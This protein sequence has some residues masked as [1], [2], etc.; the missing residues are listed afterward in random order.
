MKSSLKAKILAIS[1]E[2]FDNGKLRYL[3][4]KDYFVIQTAMNIAEIK[5]KWFVEEKNQ[6]GILKITGIK[7]MFGTGVRQYIGMS[8]M[9]QT[10]VES[11]LTNNSRV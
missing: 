7:P 9:L 1:Y 4:A 11:L 6:M 8:K 10:E 5:T 2:E 3:T